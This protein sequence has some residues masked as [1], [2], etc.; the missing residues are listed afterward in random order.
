MLE[1]YLAVL[2]T[3]V[4]DIV[5]VLT[6]CN[7]SLAGEAAVWGFMAGQGISRMPVPLTG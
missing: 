5:H 4:H 6:G 3:S 7:T 1:N 2:Y